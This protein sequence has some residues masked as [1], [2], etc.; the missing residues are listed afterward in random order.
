[1]YLL[2]RFIV[3]SAGIAS[4]LNIPAQDSPPP[5]V[6]FQHIEK[7]AGSLSFRITKTR[8]IGYWAVN[9]KL[10]GKKRPMKLQIDDGSS[11]TWILRS[12]ARL[13]MPPGV[14]S[15]ATTASFRDAYKP[16][17]E[18]F[19]FEYASD[20]WVRGHLGLVDLE[21]GGMTVKDMKLGFATSLRFD[22]GGVLS[23]VIGLR[24]KQGYRP[25]VPPT[26]K[27][28]FLVEACK[29]AG[30]DGLFYAV[31]IN[32]GGTGYLHIG[33]PLRNRDQ[34][35]TWHI[36]PAERRIAG[37]TLSIDLVDI[38]LG[39]ANKPDYTYSKDTKVT[40]DLGSSHLYLPREFAQE[41]QS[42][43]Q[44]KPELSEGHLYEVDCESTTNDLDSFE[45]AFNDDSGRRQV[46]R[47]SKEDYILKIKG[48]CTLAVAISETPRIELGAPFALNS[49]YGLD[50]KEA[51]V[52]LKQK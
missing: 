4:S 14:K 18:E 32:R 34:P 3:L 21:V 50:F 38:K 27:T 26:P 17:S 46:I 22:T 12:G 24:L 49:K 42:H 19:R 52:H 37:S 7:R 43:F 1:M 36:I 11:H 47:I 35:N 30:Y 29:E 51:V 8:D 5:S 10:G 13:L 6:D 25:D 28:A 41:F 15:L 48:T 31:D 40:F 23:G 2:L 39:V 33:D 44:P 9:A 16:L 20:E 45:F